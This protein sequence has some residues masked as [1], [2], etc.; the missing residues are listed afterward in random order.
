MTTHLANIFTSARM[1]AA[2]MTSI[3]LPGILAPTASSG[4]SD[5]FLNFSN[6]PFVRPEPTITSFDAPGAGTGPGQGT[7]PFA[8]NPAGTV[9]GYY[10]DASDARHGFL[11]NRNG[12]ITTF[13]PPGAGTGPGEGTN[14]FSITPAGAIAGRYVDASDVFHGFLRTPDGAI[15]TFDVPGAGTGPGQGTRAGNIIRRER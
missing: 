15:T 8:I 10:I 3:L 12:A 9:I 6:T 4:T 13:D 5:D 14:A 7:L 2:A 1:L 11:R